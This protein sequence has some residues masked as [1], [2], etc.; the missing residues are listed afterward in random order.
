MSSFDVCIDTQ[1]LAPTVFTSSTVYA[2]QLRIGVQQWM[3]Q[4]LRGEGAIKNALSNVQKNLLDLV[5]FFFIS[6]T[7]F[8]IPDF[9]RSYLELTF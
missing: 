7:I 5:C 6:P 4:W 3:S 2:A 8:L 9:R 1:V